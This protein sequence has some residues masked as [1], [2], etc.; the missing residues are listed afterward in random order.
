MSKAAWIWLTAALLIVGLS[1]VGGRNGSA[2][3]TVD[4]RLREEG[5]VADFRSRRTDTGEPLQPHH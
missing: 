1:F 2:Q 5:E 3:A 4:A